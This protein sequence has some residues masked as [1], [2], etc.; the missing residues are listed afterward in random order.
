MA[1]YRAISAGS[2]ACGIDDDTQQSIEKSAA[3]RVQT[4]PACG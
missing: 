1:S 3:D 2:I 4:I